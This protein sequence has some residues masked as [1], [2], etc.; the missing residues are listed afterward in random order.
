MTKEEFA[1]RHGAAGVALLC[2]EAARAWR[3]AAPNR[4]VVTFAWRGTRFRSTLTSFRM[5][6]QTAAG[7]PIAHRWGGP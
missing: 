3:A 2:N 6:V 5:L 4:R 1:K 7:E